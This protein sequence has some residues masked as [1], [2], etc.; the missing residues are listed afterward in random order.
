MC[1][2]SLAPRRVCPFVTKLS[3]SAASFGASIAPAPQGG[4]PPAHMQTHY[5]E[6]LQRDIDR[7]RRKLTEMGGLA[8]RALKNC[9]SALIERNRQ[10]AYS[11]ILRDQH[12]DELEKEIDRL[13]LEFIVRQQ[14]VAGTL[15]FAYSTIKVNLEL[16][17]VG[18][19]A[20]SVARQILVVSTMDMPELP[21]EPFVKIAGLAIPMLHDAVKAFATQDPEL[22]R[23]AMET[24]PQVDVLRHQTNADLVRLLQA[25]KIPVEA[26][27]PLMTFVNRFERVADQAKSICQEVLYSA[28]GEY[29]KHRGNEVFRVLFVDEHNACRSQM[30]E[31][32][33]NALGQPKFIFAGA[34][35]DPTRIDQATT[36]F[37][38]DKGIEVMRPQLRSVEQV[39][40]LDHYQV[41]VALADD[42][43]K[44]FPPPPTKVV[45]LDWSIKDPSKVH[46][47]A[48]EVRAAYEETYQFLHAHIQDLV[49][50]ILGD[51]VD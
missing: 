47:P 48:E 43:R 22:A 5:E 21:Q 35:L 46:G 4:A 28:T 44:V 9:L 25:G 20:E 14:P 6:T 2:P 17:R 49:E 19:Y 11:V 27:T 42:A 39:P 15:R 16:E 26:L 37:L 13:C 1:P 8:Q 7:I 10:L 51:D 34:G 50:A 38:R 40:N 32:V 24:E 36:T 45:C 12:I 29:T 18:D 33:G 41:I 3:P 23:K 31:A 30:A